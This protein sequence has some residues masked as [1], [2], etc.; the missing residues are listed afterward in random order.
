[1]MNY[2]LKLPFH[3]RHKPLSTGLELFNQQ[4]RSQQLSMSGDTNQNSFMRKIYHVKP[5]NYLSKALPLVTATYLFWLTHC[6]VFVYNSPAPAK[7]RW[8]YTV[9]PQ[10]P[11]TP[12]LERELARANWRSEDWREFYEIRHN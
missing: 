11:H 12:A 10:L 4:K 3:P 9:Y 6:S 1:M 7:N 8:G 5:K 2:Q